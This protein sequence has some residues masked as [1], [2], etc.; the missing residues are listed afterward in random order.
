[1]ATPSRRRQRGATL[2]EVL[3]S[4]VVLSIGLLGAAALQSS[5]LRNNQSSY[6]TSQMTVLGQAMLDAMRNNLAGVDAGG[7]QN[8]SYVCAAPSGSGLA[9]ADMRRWI[10]DLQSQINRSACGRIS[11]TAR[12]CTVGIRWDDARATAGSS[13]FEYSIV[14]RL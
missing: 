1:M 13:A 10:G 3:V 9:T 7:Y 2:I 11:C 6:E 8:A 5:A 4:V 14:S 12:T